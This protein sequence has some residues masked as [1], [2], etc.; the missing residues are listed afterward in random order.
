VDAGDERL[1]TCGRCERTGRWCDRTIP[2]KIRVRTVSRGNGQQKAEERAEQGSPFAAEEP[3][4]ELQSQEIAQCFE[5]YLKVLAPWYDLNDLDNS[6]KSVVGKQALRSSLLLSAIVAF[7]AIHQSRT[8]RAGLKV[9]AESYHAR[10]LR[11][12]I[13]LEQADSA[14]SDG[15]AL[16]ATCLLRSY[17][18]M[19][20]GR[21][22]S[23][24]YLTIA[25]WEKRRRTPT[26]IFSAPF[27]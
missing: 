6:F 10:C 20:G 24:A 13:G 4:A 21:T 25:D 18:I 11:L 15:T 5:H 3:I 14:I 1:P 23:I 7:A 2:L 26:A 16:A 19:A 8:G 17:E 22:T 9:L 12:L 27:H